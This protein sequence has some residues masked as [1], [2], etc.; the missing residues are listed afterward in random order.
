MR[1]NIE[2]YNIDGEMVDVWESLGGNAWLTSL[3][4]TTDIVYAADAGTRVVWGFNRKGKPVIRIDGTGIDGLGDVFVVPSPYFDIAVTDENS[5][6]VV[7]PGLH[8]LEKYRSNG[9]LI[10]SWERSS[11]QI[12][13]F[14][15]CCNPS[16]IALMPNGS[17]VTSEKG[18]P[19]VKIH[20]P[21]GELLCVVAGPE[22]FDAKVTG[23]D[24]AVDS[25]GRILVL[26]TAMN[27]IRIFERIEK[28]ELK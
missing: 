3:A 4:V 15:G 11:F 12:D 16:H 21:T 2:V 5:I 6:W 26:D 1:D 24:L 17:F 7:N 20:G 25:N 18:L 22:Q 8:A 9:A 28:R 14:C 10:T 27:K 13:G 23:L 19:R